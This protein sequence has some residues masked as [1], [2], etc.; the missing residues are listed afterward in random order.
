VLRQ[1]GVIEYR[2]GDKGSGAAVRAALSD[3]LTRQGLPVLLFPEGTSQVAGPPRPFRTGGMAVAFDVGTPVQPV[4][5]WYSEPIGL[6]PETDALAG[7]ANMLRHPTQAIVKFAPLLWPKDYADAD[8][9]AAACEQS[10][11]DAYQS[12]AVEYAQEAEAAPA[13]PDSKQKAKA[14]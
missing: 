1:V 7:T 14:S 4:A 8:A 2:R 3:A 12:V 10:V 11:R 6:A 13:S 5:L 9:F